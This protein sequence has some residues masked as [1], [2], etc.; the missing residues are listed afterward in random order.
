MFYRTSV[1]SIAHAFEDVKLTLEQMFDFS[2]MSRYAETSMKGALREHDPL[3]LQ[4][5]AQ[6]RFAVRA[7]AQGA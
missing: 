6:Q 2:H 5:R 3:R 1:L 4:L 7:T